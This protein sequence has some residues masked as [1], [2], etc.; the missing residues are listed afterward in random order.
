VFELSAGNQVLKLNAVD[1]SWNINWIDVT[2][3]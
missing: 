3:Q 1:D 2:T